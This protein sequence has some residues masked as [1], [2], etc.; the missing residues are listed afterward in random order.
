MPEPT[1]ALNMR[2]LGRRLA[3]EECVLATNNPS[4]GWGALVNKQELVPRLLHSSRG[5][6]SDTERTLCHQDVAG[7]EWTLSHVAVHGFG[8]PLC[9]QPRGHQGAVLPLAPLEWSR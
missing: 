1:G 4:V 3:G 2:L 6:G 8:G 9:S 5:S 7:L